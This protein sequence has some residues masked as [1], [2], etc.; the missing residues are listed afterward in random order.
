M[1][2]TQVT[3]TM[4]TINIRA[5]EKIFGPRGS[6]QLSR[7]MIRRSPLKDVTYLIETSR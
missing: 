3:D 6:E 1:T 2:P 7:D 5:S 4:K